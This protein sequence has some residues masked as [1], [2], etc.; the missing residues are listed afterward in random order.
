[1]KKITQIV[2]I[3]LIA[4]MVFGSG[5]LMRDVIQPQNSFIIKIASGSTPTPEGCN[6][7]EVAV[8]FSILNQFMNNFNDLDTIARSTSR[9][10]L[11]TPIMK[12][13][14]VKQQFQQASG[15]K[16]TATATDYFLTYM[17]KDINAYLAFSTEAPDA[18]VTKQ[19]KDARD[20][21]DLTI[22]EIS[23]VQRCMPNCKN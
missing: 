5:F 23:N 21:H 16:C 20:F 2:V 14:E 8:Y 1:M 7:Q 17:E 11:T 22:S 18:E 10:N 12:M 4:L 15:P 6:P 19:L 13:Q 9:I 3:I